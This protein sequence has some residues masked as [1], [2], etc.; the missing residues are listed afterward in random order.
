MKTQKSTRLVLRW[1]GSCCV[2][3]LCWTSWLALCVLLFV[4]GWIAVRRQLP[5][6]DYLLR[7][8][9]QRLAESGVIARFVQVVVD[10]GGRIV[11]GGLRLYATGQDEPLVES[12]AALAQ[13]DPWF[14][15]KI[16]R[17]HV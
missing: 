4:L 1:C 12:R 11:V 3:F 8:G 6:P 13:L 5:V 9:E 2:S 17:A 16:G 15:F 14:L 7:R 10:P